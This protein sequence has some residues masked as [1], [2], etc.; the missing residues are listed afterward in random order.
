MI[1]KNQSASKT[2]AVYSSAAWAF[3]GAGISFN[4]AAL[5]FGGSDRAQDIG[6]TLT[7]EDIIPRNA[8]GT[9]Q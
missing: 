8:E 9:R 5:E 2:N 4:Q 1:P 7:I 3:N 6:P